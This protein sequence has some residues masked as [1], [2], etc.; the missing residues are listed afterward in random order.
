MPTAKKPASKAKT[1]KQATAA[2]KSVA[3]PTQPKTASGETAAVFARLKRI[4]EKYAPDLDLKDDSAVNYYLNA[5]KPWNKKELFFGA[6]AVRKSY[7]SFY[8]F[9]IYMFPELTDGLSKEL[10]KHRQGKSCFNFTR[11]DEALMQE[12]SE[13]TERGFQ[14]FQ[15]EGLI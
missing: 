12:L 1:T 7:V 15:T 10:T 6:A 13:L 9:S 4:L 11:I 8:L 5:K 2:K 14:R 3:T